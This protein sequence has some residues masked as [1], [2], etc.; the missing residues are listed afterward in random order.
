M[1]IEL[2]TPKEEAEAKEQVAATTTAELL[3]KKRVA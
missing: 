3:G 2:A 1:T